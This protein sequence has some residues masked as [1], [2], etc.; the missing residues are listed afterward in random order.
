MIAAFLSAALAVA[1]PLPAARAATLDSAL[2]AEAQ[3]GFSGVVLVARG[4]STLFLRAYGNAARSG[5]RPGDLA[6]WIA[7]DSKQ[8]TGTAI[9]AL[10]ERGRL[11]TSDSL[12]RFFPRVPADKRGIT[13][14]QLLTHTS[15]LPTEYV[16]E[17]IAD[18][19]QAVAAI[20]ALPLASRPGEKFSYSNDG[21]NL[22]AAIVEVASG[23][24]FDQYLADSLIARA[25]LRHTGVW[26]HEPA[27]L[28][29]AAP[30]DPARVRR[31]RPTIWRDGHSVPNWGFRGSGGAYSTAEDLHAWVRALQAGRVL[32]PRAMA[33]LV[34]HH[35]LIR[36]SGDGES[37][38]AYGW[39]VKA[40]D[41]RDLSYGHA[42]S[43]DWLGQSSVIHWTP[44][45]DC[46]VV[47]ANSGE[48]QGEGWASR[49]N[50]AARRVLDAP[51]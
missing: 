8:F 17:G 26:G 28:V 32:G 7:S 30:P 11:R 35:W 40:K 22:L 20:L 27:A 29:F 9:L 46:V 31:Q 14:H 50:R 49:A 19:E 51:P 1:S 34:G 3:A 12:G 13:I 45:G 10:E 38:T 5:A 37:W 41:G 48:T 39:G 21:Y 33:E 15:G 36:K 2:R 24:P 47:L 4:D 6:F 25:G 18:R 23:V 16:A 43:D 44:D 42:G